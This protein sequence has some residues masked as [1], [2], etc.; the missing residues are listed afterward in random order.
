[1]G[2]FWV[3]LGEV[4]FLADVGLYGNAV[5]LFL[6]V[7]WTGR[8]M[9]RTS[10]VVLLAA[11][12]VISIVGLGDVKP[13]QIVKAHIAYGDGSSKEIDLLCR[14]DTAEEVEYYKAGG[15]LQY[16]LLGLAA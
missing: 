9:T 12:P 14:I 10:A 8:M 15:I 4:V 11:L 16:V 5:V 3:L 1:M 7:F 6:Q 2:F 13:R